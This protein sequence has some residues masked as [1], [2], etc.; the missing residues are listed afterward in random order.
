M[1]WVVVPEMSARAWFRAKHKMLQE[2]ARRFIFHPTFFYSLSLPTL[3]GKD[4]D[5]PCCVP[6]VILCIPQQKP[7]STYELFATLLGKR[8]GAPVLMLSEESYQGLCT[9]TLVCVWGCVSVGSIPWKHVEKQIHFWLHNRSVGA[10]LP[11]L[12]G[13]VV[14]LPMCVQCQRLGKTSSLMSGYSIFHKIF[15]FFLIPRDV[16]ARVLFESL[17]LFVLYADP[18]QARFGASGHVLRAW[19]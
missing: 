6:A 15:L 10:P 12:L 2:M 17:L 16:H 14:P 13:A 3:K 11:P 1:L 19:T 8:S 9:T 7:K 18:I 5:G 4:F